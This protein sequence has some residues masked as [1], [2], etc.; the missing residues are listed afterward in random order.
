MIH[1]PMPV[2]DTGK[3]ADAG[4]AFQERLAVRGVNFS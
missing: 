1:L 3:I 4:A 2:E